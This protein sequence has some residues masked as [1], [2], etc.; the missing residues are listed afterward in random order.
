M[1]QFKMS[2]NKD[3]LTEW[4][5]RM[6]AQGWAMTDYV[7]GFYRFA[8]CKPGEYIYQVDIAENLFSVSEDYQQF[9]EEMG[10]EIVCLWGPW[11]FLR[12]KASEGGFEMY[13][14]VESSVRHYTKIKRMFQTL[15]GIIGACL[16]LGIYGAV[17]QKRIILWGIVVTVLILTLLFL[18]AIVHLGRILTELNSRLGRKTSEPG[19][20][21]SVFASVMHAA[22]AGISMLFAFFLYSLLHEAGHCIP[23]WLC[24]GTV[25]GFYPTDLSP[26]MT[27]E[28]ITGSL[29]LGLVD[30]AGSLLPLIT[31]AAILLFYKGSKKHPWLNIYLGFLSGAFIFSLTP[32]ILEPIIGGQQNS[33]VSH[34]INH[35]GLHPAVVMLC[36]IIVFVLMCLL[37]VK[38]LPKL[39]GGIVSKKFIISIAAVAIT[40]G[41]V[42]ATLCQLFE[43]DKLLAKGNVRYTV[44]SSQN[45][46]LQEEFTI[47]IEQPGEY[48]LYAGCEVDRD[49]V[50]A[51]VVFWD[52]DKVYC[53]CTGATLFQL[54]SLPFH[55]DSGSYTLSFYLLSSE[56][57]WQEYCRITGSAASAIEDFPYQPDAPATVTGSYSLVYKRSKNN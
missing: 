12:R 11:V 54:E 20:M 25:T 5:G 39:F 14:D 55:L 10:V 52:E 50:I 34:F 9:M 23:V 46:M 40:A 1:I 32:W 48:V 15:G 37:F 57:D 16:L 24:G 41:A 29:P 36:A 7:L 18:R 30:I 17:S 4:L 28:G 13:T 3:K 49:G 8:K 51:A 26:H 6:A 45:S 33:D 56:E 35:T 22:G 38:K 43:A 19:G 42:I 53:H 47:E 27:Y 44:E 21:S 2:Y 31:V